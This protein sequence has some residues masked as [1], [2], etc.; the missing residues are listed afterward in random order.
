MSHPRSGLQL[1]DRNAR[2]APGDSGRADSD[3]S[4]DPSDH[5]EARSTVT[6]CGRERRQCS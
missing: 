5:V 4:P 3:Y 2:I 1:V 6:D